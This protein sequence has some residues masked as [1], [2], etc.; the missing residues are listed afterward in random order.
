MADSIR[1]TIARVAR[2]EGIDPAYALA[3]ADRESKF[4]PNL[5]GT[6]SIRGLYQMTGRVRRDHGLADDASPEDQTRA[7]ARF[8]K[9]VQGEM[10]GVMGR[11][12]THDETYLGHHFGGVRAGRTVA[13][14][15]NGFAPGDVFSP[16]EMAGNTHFGKASSMDELARSIKA[17]MGRRRSKFGGAG[18]EAGPIDFAQFGQRDGDLD[19][20][21]RDPNLPTIKD[22]GTP[23]PRGP[24]QRFDF[25]QF[26]LP[27]QETADIRQNPSVP[28]VQ[29]STSAAPPRP[30]RE[31]DLSKYGQPMAPMPQ[32]VQAFAA[33]GAM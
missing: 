11:D 1:D 18:G 6:G 9:A 22:A 26:G 31:I 4:N 20:P 7:F 2:E 25:A 8:T 23:S 12:P 15:Y 33:P 16:R 17:D 32:S 13:G 10:R 29:P 27:E 30:G 19:S 28:D 3:V 24:G 5:A 14:Q 21:E